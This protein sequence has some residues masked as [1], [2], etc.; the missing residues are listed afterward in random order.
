MWRKIGIQNENIFP[1]NRKVLNYQPMEGIGKGSRLQGVQ[2]RQLGKSI[3]Q[4]HRRLWQLIVRFVQ[5]KK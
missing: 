3:H 5:R 2:Y 4:I 1:T